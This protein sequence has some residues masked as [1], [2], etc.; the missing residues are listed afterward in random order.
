MK[1]AVYFC[2]CKQPL[3][4]KSIKTE[5]GF[6]NTEWSEFSS[7]AIILCGFEAKFHDKLFST[8]SFSYSSHCIGFF[9]FPNQKKVKAK[10][11]AQ[12]LIPLMYYHDN[13]AFGSCRT[14]WGIA[15]NIVHVY[16]HEVSQTVRHEQSPD[17]VLH[18]LLYVTHNQ[19]HV[20]QGTQNNSLG[21]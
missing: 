13:P 8:T 21:Q 12:N 18:H 2:V 4:L 17:A 10:E 19:S 9:H 15:M 6:C 7:Y 16:T 14:P 1:R 20:L 3:V 11:F 5:F